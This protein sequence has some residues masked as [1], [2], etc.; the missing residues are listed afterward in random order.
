MSLSLAAGLLIAAALVWAG[1]AL[2]QANSSC[3]ACQLANTRW[4]FA[5][6]DGRRDLRYSFNPMFCPHCGWSSE[7]ALD[8]SV[9]P[10]LSLSVAASGLSAVPVV[11]RA[12]GPRGGT[13]K[14]T[15]LIAAALERIARQSG[16]KARLDVLKRA[17][18][19][20]QTA[21]GQQALIDHA[22]RIEVHDL[23]ARLPAMPA[24]RRRRELQT[25]L[26][27][28]HDDDHSDRL[29]VEAIDQLR[30]LLDDEVRRA[31]QPSAETLES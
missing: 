23:V 9:R 15:H 11:V 6:Q 7:T 28:L 17:L 24:K 13:P 2:W 27:R 14:E 31:R 5:R 10:A 4:T 21:K 25:A 22:S 8:D 30:R 12:Q 3:P 29:Q 26:Q 1:R 19:D 16:R 18:Q 20:V